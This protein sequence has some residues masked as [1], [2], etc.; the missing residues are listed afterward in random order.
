MINT[1][2]GREHR[3]CIKVC[4]AFTFVDSFIDDASKDF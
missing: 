3:S 2:V 1:L 4:L